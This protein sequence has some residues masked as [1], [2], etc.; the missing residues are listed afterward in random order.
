MG[1]NR[2][3][4]VFCRTRPADSKEH[5]LPLWLQPY[6]DPKGGGTFVHHYNDPAG[7][8]VRVWG[9]DRPDIKVKR[10]C[11][12]HC[13]NGWMSD[14][15][16]AAQ[17][18]VGS[19]IKGY[20]RTLYRHGQQLIACWAVKTALMW[21]FATPTQALPDRWFA[22]LYDGRSEHRIPRGV[23]IWIGACRT[24]GIGFFKSCGLRLKKKSGEQANGY[25]VTFTVG[26]LVVQI[27]GHEFG[28]DGALRNI[29][30]GTRLE[31]TMLPIWPHVS[32]IQMPPDF[33]LTEP[34]L[35]Q[36]AKEFVNDASLLQ[37]RDSRD[38]SHSLTSR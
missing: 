3:M 33:V 1:K 30:K 20:G 23:Q 37:R 27:F 13:N 32:Q 28:E 14:L 22:E 4:C 17:P 34:Q 18:V 8:P 21:E 19:L 12:E 36:L 2:R 11:A 35:Q 9:A 25:G 6:L 16:T 29:R 15:E 31:R 7:E 26:R 10:T 38:V 5:A 24:P